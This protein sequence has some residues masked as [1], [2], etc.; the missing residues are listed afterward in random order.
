MRRFA[1]LAIVL[2]AAPASAQEERA[3]EPAYDTVVLSVGGDAP[4]EVAREAREAVAR[5]L[6]ADG[7]RVL[8]EGELALRA[9]PSR[10]H[11][12]GSIACAWALGRELG[13]SMV[14][15]VAVWQEGGA[16]S[17][18]TVSLVVGEARAHAASEDLG[19]RSL[20]DAAAAAVRGAQNA[21]ARALIGEG[22]VA[23]APSREHAQE[24][25]PEHDPAAPRERSLEEYVLPTVLGL[26][27]LGL[28]AAGVYA[29][30]PV[31]C[32]LEGPSGT[33][34]RG[35]GPNVGLG[36]LFAVTGG[37]AIGGAILWLVVGGTPAP[38]GRIDVVL[39]PE[40]GGLS[41]RGTF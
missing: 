21:R 17:S 12:C 3:S 37:L 6:E 29:L 19:G 1:C 30:L 35:N 22:E 40:G 41:W 13:A 32:E 10:L 20:A 5:A 8:P 31:Q 14:A 26:V 25:E 11:G 34:L 16:P 24:S 7:L 28:A 36:A 9:P 15:A 38:M 39:A 18:I 23:A 4:A 2:A 27:G 33:C